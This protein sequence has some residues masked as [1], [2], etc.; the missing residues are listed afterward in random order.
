MGNPPSL[1]ARW[2]KH[3]KSDTLDYC[4][5]SLRHDIVWTSEQRDTYR[6]SFR[7]DRR[8]IAWR[9][10]HSNQHRQGCGY[11]KSDERG[12]CVYHPQFAAGDVYRIGRVAGLSET[13][14]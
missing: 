9:F 10:H 2:R 12:G 13:E 4:V 5:V 1:P 7:C 11:D 14:L 3:E 6:N 8:D